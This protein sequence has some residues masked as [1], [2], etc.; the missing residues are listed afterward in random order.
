MSNLK[1]PDDCIDF[2][3]VV[4]GEDECNNFA[5]N[6]LTLKILATD[7]KDNQ[8]FTAAGLKKNAFPNGIAWLWESKDLQDYLAMY[9]TWLTQ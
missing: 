4:S 3:D 9:N 5:L 8:Y 7:T 2:S 1:L 6:L